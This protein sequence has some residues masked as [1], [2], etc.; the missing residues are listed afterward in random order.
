MRLWH[1]KLIPYLPR[2]QLCG[3]WR[4]CCLIAKSIAEKGTPNHLLVNKVMDYPEDEF[5]LY[6]EQVW[7]EMWRRGYKCDWDKFSRYRKDYS[8]IDR[9]DKLF[10]G[11]HNTR[12]LKQCLNNLEEKYDC[13]GLT[14]EEWETLL[15]GYLSIPKGD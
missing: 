12:Y 7:Q 3:Q 4:E 6:G 9:P 5:T 11:W 10:K 15:T 14:R 8:L 1:Y 2:Q 13:G